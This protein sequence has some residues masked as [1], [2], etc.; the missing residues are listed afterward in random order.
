[1]HFFG[2]GLQGLYRRGTLKNY[3][4]APFSQNPNSDEIKKNLMIL[5]VA[6]IQCALLCNPTIYLMM[7]FA[8][9]PTNFF[10]K[11]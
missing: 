5:I 3:L 4:R 7:P 8:K 10:I 11:I 1:M 2:V 9:Y 6:T